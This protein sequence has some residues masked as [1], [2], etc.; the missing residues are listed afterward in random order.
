MTLTR[1]GLPSASTDTRCFGSRG[2]ISVLWVH[3]VILLSTGHPY[4][5]VFSLPYVTNYTKKSDDYKSYEFC[6][7]RENFM[8]R[9][10]PDRSRLRRE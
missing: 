7:L 8:E 6:C 2:G 9:H 3:C 4:I 1:A 5:E 10:V